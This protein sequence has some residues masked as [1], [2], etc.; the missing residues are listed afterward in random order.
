MHEHVRGDAPETV[1]QPMSA[2]HDESVTMGGI[3]RFCALAGASTN[4]RT[5]PLESVGACVTKRNR[6]F[7]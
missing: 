6:R 3:E 5:S 1:S 7:L 2:E 4:A